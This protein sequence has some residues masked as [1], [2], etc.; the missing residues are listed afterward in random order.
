MD[1]FLA[2]KDRY[3]SK[4]FEDEM[5]EYYPL[6]QFG[7]NNRPAS[8]DTPLHGLVPYKHIDHMHPDWSIALAASGNGQQKLQEFN[9][10]FGY[11]LVWLPWQ[12]P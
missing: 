12:R 11:N 1:K 7:L 3:R 10:Q 2:L 4:E 8:I 6:C 5:V 9:E